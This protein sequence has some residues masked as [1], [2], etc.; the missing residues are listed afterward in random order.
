M[1]PFIPPKLRPAIDTLDEENLEF[2]EG[3]LA[4]TWRRRYENGFCPCG[5]TM[6]IRTLR[7]V[8]GYLIERYETHWN[9]S[10]AQD[11]WNRHRHSMR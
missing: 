7:D 8:A 9:W 2:L 6:T 1:G 11:E 3:D 4:T 10:Q 5:C